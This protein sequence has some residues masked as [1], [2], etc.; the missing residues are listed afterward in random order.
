MDERRR[1]P[2]GPVD[3]VVGREAEL[4][5]HLPVVLGDLEHPALHGGAADPARDQE[6]AIGQA[7]GVYQLLVYQLSGTVALPGNSQISVAVLAVSSTWYSTA[8]EWNMVVVPP[9]APAA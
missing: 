1:D 9:T 3:A 6:I 4:P 2:V 7:N 5:D 8:R